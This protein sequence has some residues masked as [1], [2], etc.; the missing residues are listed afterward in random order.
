MGTGYHA[1][2]LCRIVADLFKLVIRS[3]QGTIP[4]TGVFKNFNTIEEFKSTEGKKE[5]FTSAVDSVSMA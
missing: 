4:M 2:D 5:L 3:P 1:D